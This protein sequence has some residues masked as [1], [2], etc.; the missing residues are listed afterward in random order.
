[1]NST[2]VIEGVHRHQSPPGAPYSTLRMP[3]KRLQDYSCLTFDCYGTLI[4]WESGFIEAFR[5]LTNRL[6]ATH[7]LRKEPAAVLRLYGQYEPRI[8]AQFPTLKYSAILE[9]VYEQIASEC[10]LGA[11]ITSADKTAFGASIGTWTSFPDTIEALQRLKRHFKLVILSNVD[12]ESFS[13]TLSG[14]L[15][16]ASFD[17]VYVAEEIGSY[18]PDLRNF[19]YLV[20]HCKSDLQ[21]KKEKILHTAYSLPADLKPAKEFELTGCLIERYPNVMGGDL[22]KMKDEVAVDFRFPTLRDM[23]DEADRLF[24]SPS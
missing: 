24:S 2:N 17:A 5:S 1:M 9:K 8:Q 19:Q 12:K 23:A 22:E 7:S 20:D 16:A 10:G 14:P 21:V 4:D 13:R 3:P 11:T 18:K 15:S 6:S